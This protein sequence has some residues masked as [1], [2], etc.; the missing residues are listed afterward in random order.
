MNGELRASGRSRSLRREYLKEGGC[1]PAS[2]LRPLTLFTLIWLF[3]FSSDLAPA[4]GYGGLGA[5]TDGFAEVTPGRVFAFPEDHGAHEDFR[6]EWWYVTANLTGPDGTPYG[7]QWT[8]FRMAS[9]PDKGTGWASN[10]GWMAHAALTTTDRHLVAEKLSRG[11]IGQAGVTAEPFEAWIDDWQMRGSFQTLDL[12]AGG[13][14]FAY[15]LRLEADLPPILHGDKGY[16]VKSED[17]QASY[18]YAQPFYAVTG[19]ISLDGTDIP[20]TGKAWLDREWSTQPLTA[21]QEG[22]DWVSLHL[23]GGDKLMLYRLRHREG[24]DY[25]VGTWIA[26][27]GTARA[28]SPGD[29]ELI[30]LRTA[31][32]DGRPHPVEWR[33]Q[34][35]PEAVD[36]TLRALNPQAH[37]DTLF[38]YWEGPVRISGSHDGVGYL[39][40]TGY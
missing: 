11:G 18:Y 31:K 38:D 10:Q 6:I 32:V 39:E 40:M 20:V 30:P 17:G 26:R 28:L 23:A 2:I 34:Y 19:A 25:M 36:L 29:A 37:M 9:R 27:D 24:D 15:D 4:Q 3:T 1:G 22:W 12:T 16:S 7:I 8:L 13:A 21:D 33:V 14:D 35:G 5:E